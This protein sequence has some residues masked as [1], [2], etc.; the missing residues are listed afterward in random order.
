MYSLSETSINGFC[1]SNTDAF[2]AGARLQFER[3]SIQMRDFTILRG[4][5]RHTLLGKEA[6]QFALEN[7][8]DA[9]A[10]GGNTVQ[11]EF[12][13]VQ[14]EGW[15]RLLS[16]TDLAWVQPLVSASVS[17]FSNFEYSP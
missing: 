16:H 17:D 15:A 4:C 13:D 8:A 2:C 6:C 11:Y 10:V 3:A 14:L 12:L 1:Q 9:I 5:R 7:F